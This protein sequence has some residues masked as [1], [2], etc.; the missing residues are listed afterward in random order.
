MNLDKLKPSRET[1][2]QSRGVAKTKPKARS[3][4]KAKILSAL[5][6]ATT[7]SAA[8]GLEKPK[9]KPK[10]VYALGLSGSKFPPLAVQGSEKPPLPLNL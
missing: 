9:N 6:V 8:E 10:K 2:T 1:K 5:A 7:T 3:T 4:P